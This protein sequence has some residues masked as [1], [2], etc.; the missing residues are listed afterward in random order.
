MYICLGDK[1]LKLNKI[2]LDYGN[3]KG[4]NNISFSIN[5]GKICGVLGNNGSGKSTTFRIILGLLK[6]DSGEI[7]VNN[8]LIDRSDKCLLGYL[9]EERSLIRSLSVYE[10]IKHLSKLKKMSDIDIENSLDYW[11]KYLNIEEYKYSRISSLSKG[12]QQKI[13]IICALIHNPK[14][15]IF[16]EPF[17][18]LDIDNVQL[19]KMLLLKLKSEKKIILISSHQ[20]NSIEQYCD[21]VVYLKK[22]IIVF[23]GVVKTIKS[24]YKKRFIKINS[25]DKEL[26]KYEGI[27]DYYY[28]GIYLILIVS[29]KQK[30]LS[31]ADK[32]IKKG[33]DD[34]SIELA[35]LKY[36][37]KEKCQ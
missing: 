19:F 6:P 9:P 26:T 14:I 1:M 15:I 22:G 33:I 18:G 21:N 16:D 36:I 37:I 20:Y 32:L 29:D 28:D 31:I 5:S 12:N 8:Q 11:L 24:R 3:G 2:C 27:T 7:Y 13:Q 34:F 25:K 35:S 4:V 30:A 10:Q 23:K 17:N